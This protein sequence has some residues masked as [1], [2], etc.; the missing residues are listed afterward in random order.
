[1]PCPTHHVCTPPLSLPHHRNEIRL[2]EL[3]LDAQD[4]MSRAVKAVEDASEANT[5][6]LKNELTLNGIREQIRNGRMEAELA[7]LREENA[8]LSSELAETRFLL[9]ESESQLVLTAHYVECEVSVCERVT[10]G[11]R[12]REGI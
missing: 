4:S 11:S 1:M 5:V 9:D 8:L 10:V 7:E 2:A 12:G 3:E 6:S